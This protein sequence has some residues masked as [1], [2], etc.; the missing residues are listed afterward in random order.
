MWWRVKKLNKINKII[1]GILTIFLF[2]GTVSA[3][4]N[5]VT[6][7]W[8]TDFHYTKSSDFNTLSTLYQNWKVQ[9]QIMS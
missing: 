7:G 8:I 6:F 1:I 3:S 2:I 5:E 9:M 4:N